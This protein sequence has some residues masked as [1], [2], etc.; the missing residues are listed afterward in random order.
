MDNYPLSIRPGVAAV[1]LNSENEVLLHLR[2]VG[3]A[4]APPSGSMEPGET[5]L[6]A[7]KRELLEET[8]LEVRVEHLV[9]VYSDP[10]IQIVHYPDGRHIHFVTTLFLC[11]VK[12]GN[13]KGCSEGM[14]WGWFPPDQLPENLL[15]YARI[16]I[17]DAVAEHPATLVK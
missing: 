14:E 15:P 13:L 7:L 11:R 12:K 6:K 8:G 10:D 16:W 5:V 3:G 9:A 2:R 1:I 4:W 17:A